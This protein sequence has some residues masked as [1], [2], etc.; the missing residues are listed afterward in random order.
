MEYTELELVIM[1]ENLDESSLS[2]ERTV[3]RTVSDLVK[4]E[5][6]S[7]WFIYLTK[8]GMI[9]LLFASVTSIFI[10]VFSLVALTCNLVEYHGPVLYGYVSPIRYE[11]RI[12]SAV[13]AYSN[14][15]SVVLISR[16]F[17]L[18][19]IVLLILSTM[20]L[21]LII[22]AYTRP[23]QSSTDRRTINGVRRHWM[24]FVMLS[25]IGSG[26]L[27]MLLFSILRVLAY[28]IVPDLPRSIYLT[29]STGR[30]YIYSPFAE[31]TWVMTDLA[32]RP[33]FFIILF[34]LAS[35]ATVMTVIYILLIPRPP[36]TKISR[37][38]KITKRWRETQ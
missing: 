8:G 21:L 20:S 1:R 19:A 32:W 30:V 22:K 12:D 6:E 25:P 29:S 14:L 3:S 36:V 26:L 28:D 10:T 7:Y 38:K 2:G 13:L 15:D 5:L 9:V 4:K 24:S 23:G 35:I 34:I 18:F 37:P 11:L 17:L 33:M 16:L 31:Y 27:S